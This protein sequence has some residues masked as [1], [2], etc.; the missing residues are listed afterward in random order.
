MDITTLI[1]SG[2]GI[3]MGVGVVWLRVD[4]VLKALK[5][6]TDVLTAVTEA[7]ADKDLSKEELAK[8]AKESKEVLI[9]IKAIF[10]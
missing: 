4:K 9:A 7:L 5:E 1:L 6:V 10:K 3:V 2:A 8:I